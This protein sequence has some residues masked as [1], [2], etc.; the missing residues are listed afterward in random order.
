MSLSV[1]SSSPPHPA[2]RVLCVV[3]HV[4]AA[5]HIVRGVACWSHMYRSVAP[6]CSHMVGGGG[7]GGDVGLGIDTVLVVIVDRYIL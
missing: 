2:T 6:A 3:L 4:A 7:D 1:P 5:S